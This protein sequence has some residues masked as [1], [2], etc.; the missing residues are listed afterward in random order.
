MTSGAVDA[1]TQPLDGRWPYRFT[2]RD[3]EY[4][5][6]KGCWSFS[7]DSRGSYVTLPVLAGGATARPLTV[8]DAEA[9]RVLSHMGHWDCREVSAPLDRPPAG[10]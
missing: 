6:A 3:R 4:V 10:V 8:H 2:I 9:V 5:I 7:D 1:L